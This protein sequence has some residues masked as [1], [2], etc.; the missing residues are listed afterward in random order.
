MLPP[1]GVD[2]SCGRQ[3][4]R[5]AGSQ[6]FPSHWELGPLELVSRRKGSTTGNHHACK[7]LS[8]VA[9]IAGPAMLH[10]GDERKLYP[11]DSYS[12]KRIHPPTTYCKMRWHK[13]RAP[14]PLA[15]IRP[16]PSFILSHTE[17]W[18]IFH[19]ASVVTQWLMTRNTSVFGIQ[20]I[21][22]NA[23]FLSCS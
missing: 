18:T 16:M 14:F 19:W 13:A 2:F 12:G 7:I 1:H 8:L 6:I 23:Y 9:H 3:A 17:I 15:D 20:E 21:W 22:Q 10:G 4:A 11:C 5:V